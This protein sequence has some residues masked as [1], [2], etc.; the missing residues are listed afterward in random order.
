MN[1]EMA[2][3][4]LSAYL[5][6]MLEPPDH[7]SLQA[8]LESCAHCRET[9]ADYRRS[10]GALL[11]M[12]RVAPSDALRS[13][14]F[15]SPEFLAL[16]H[17]Q[18]RPQQQ[19]PDSASRRPRVERGR[20]PGAS[21]GWRRAALQVAAVFAVV[22]GSAL[23]VKQGLSTFD[24]QRGSVSTRTL[25]NPG[26]S[27][28]PLA[29]GSRVVFAHGGALWSAPEASPGLAQQL[30]PHGV[31]A[32]TWSV[33]ADRRFVAYVDLRAGTLHIIRSDGQSDTLVA[34][35]PG[36][37]ALGVPVWSPDETQLAYLAESASGPALHL[38]NVTGTNDRTIS[39]PGASA[40]T[41]VI[42]SRDGLHVAFVQTVGSAQSLWAYDLVAHAAGELA[43]NADPSTAGARF[44]RVI[45][46]P[47]TLHP[48]VSWSAV[49]AAGSFVS[50]IFTHAVASS[51]T[52]RLTPAQATYVVADFTAANGGEW[53]LGG[54][55]STATVRSVAAAS[56]AAG[57]STTLSSAISALQWSPDGNAATLLTA[58]G[59]LSLWVPG[60]APVR[61]LGGVSGAPAWAPSGNAL[62]VPTSSGV[63]V[64][65]VKDGHAGALVRLNSGAQA[66]VMA[67]VWAPDG[68]TVAIESS[69]AVVVVS[70]D[71]TRTNN[72]AAA[73][74]PGPLVW[75]I[76]G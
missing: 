17:A 68:A 45:W 12:P 21:P 34:S 75:T 31:V 28:V 60:S 65:T 23:L 25:G 5:D 16:I 57:A 29:A 41:G 72:I 53:L 11:A 66:T 20:W 9:L 71:G 38:V 22:V 40:I 74:A 27:G 14:I 3:E 48:A 67:L 47:D 69:S 61:V 46:L 56:G 42:W 15:E 51:A 6:D 76:A 58:S 10:D 19:Q 64:V 44:E 33:S 39:A 4:T 62:A 36:G 30:T 59:E 73:P 24:A 55:G 1:C 2:E 26:Q 63:F 13:R 50:G 35:A 32:G 43:A 70:A 37:R 52:Q 54:T 8:H 7:A 18:A 49:D